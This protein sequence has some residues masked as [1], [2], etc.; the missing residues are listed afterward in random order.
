M[1]VQIYG[2]NRNIRQLSLKM[3]DIFDDLTIFFP[4][5]MAGLALLVFSNNTMTILGQDWL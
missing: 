2:K 1:R 3:C 5:Y 4:K